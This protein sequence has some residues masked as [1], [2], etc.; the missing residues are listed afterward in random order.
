MRYPG[1]LPPIHYIEFA[2]LSFV[3]KVLDQLPKI[4]IA[5]QDN[6]LGAI[7]VFGLA[8]LAVVAFSLYVVLQSLH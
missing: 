8:C 4:T 6:P 2:M 7:F 3:T 1:R 5:L